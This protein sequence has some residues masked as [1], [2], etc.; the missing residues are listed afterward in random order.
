MLNKDNEITIGHKRKRNFKAMLESYIRS[1]QGMANAWEIGEV[2]VLGG[3]ISYYCMVEKD[4]IEAII[5][6]YNNRFGVDIR[7][8][9]K[10]DLA[11]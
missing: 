2:Q 7:A 4:S 5:S 6:N 8:M 9:I 10:R 11:A 3:L 1:K